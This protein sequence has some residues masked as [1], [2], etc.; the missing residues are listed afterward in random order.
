M[1]IRGHPSGRTLPSHLVDVDAAAEQLVDVD[2]AVGKL[3]DVDAAAEK[4]VDVDATGKLV[5]VDAAGAEVSSASVIP[6]S[7]LLFIFLSHTSF[8]LSVNTSILSFL[9]P[10]LRIVSSSKVMSPLS[11]IEQSATMLQSSWSEILRRP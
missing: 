5:D 3:V 7:C 2:A 11:L 6:Y 1:S 4:L 10:I 8:T 9:M